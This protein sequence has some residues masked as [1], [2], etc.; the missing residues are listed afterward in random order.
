MR[1]SE[2][3]EV[4]LKQRGDL[5]GPATE[6]DQ[7]ARDECWLRA[8]QR[9]YEMIIRRLPC[10]EARSR[11]WESQD[12]PG[13]RSLKVGS[14]GRSRRRE[15]VEGCDRVWPLGTYKNG[16]E[17]RGFLA[18]MELPRWAAPL[19]VSPVELAASN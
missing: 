13:R 15:M 1:I 14:F 10:L 7:G 17:G 9:S 6:D 4:R 12:I 2:Q 18:E 19:A 16:P 3:A 8:L 11:S 5:L